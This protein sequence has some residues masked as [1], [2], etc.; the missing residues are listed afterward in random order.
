MYVREGKSDLQGLWKTGIYLYQETF[1]KECTQRPAETEDEKS[2]WERY[3][4]GD[5]S[6]KVLHFVHR[7]KAI[8]VK[9]ILEAAEKEL[10]KVSKCRHDLPEE[11]RIYPSI[12]CEK[13]GEK[14]ME[15]RVRVRDGKLLCIPCVEREY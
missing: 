8:S 4:E 14:V 9:H 2:M 1:R 15:P 13:C 6:Q 3:A 5:R 7:R 10:M 12:Q 11:A